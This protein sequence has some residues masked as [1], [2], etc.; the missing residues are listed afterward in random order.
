[1][2]GD[3]TAIV[4]QSPDPS[5]KSNL[6][7]AGTEQPLR[8]TAA[9]VQQIQ[10]GYVNRQWLWGLLSVLKNYAS[11]HAISSLFSAPH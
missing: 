2:G 8:I 4:L 9:L 6:S 7:V 1:M 5:A 10:R 3:F 11:D